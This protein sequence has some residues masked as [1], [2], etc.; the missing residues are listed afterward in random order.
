MII[1]D[2]M[3]HNP[4]CVSEKT[5]INEAMQIMQKNKFG[6]LPVVDGSQR[7]VG[8]ITK[9]DINKAS[10]SDATTLDKYEINSLL[11]KLTCGKIMTKE[12]ISVTENEVIED[13]A[14]LMIDKEIGCVPVVKNDVVTGIVTESDLFSIFTDMLGAGYNG[15]RVNFHMENKPGKLAAFLEAVSKEN[16]N[17]ISVATRQSEKAGC[18]RVTVKATDVSQEKVKEILEGCGAEIIDLRIV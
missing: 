5:T 3:T 4:I 1:K 9:N 15:V 8:I 2:V 11:S 10:P 13:A 12:V 17:I 14:K 6:K 18:R 16:G 7:L